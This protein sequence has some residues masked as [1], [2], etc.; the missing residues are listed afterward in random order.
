MRRRL[1]IVREVPYTEYK[2]LAEDP[3]KMEMK[4]K[5]AAPS[6]CCSSVRYSCSMSSNISYPYMLAAHSLPSNKQCKEWN[7][8]R[9]NRLNAGV[10]LLPPTTIF[11]R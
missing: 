11:A 3:L 4:I 6:V 2:P 7:G 10:L 1:K 9:H 5:I 8:V